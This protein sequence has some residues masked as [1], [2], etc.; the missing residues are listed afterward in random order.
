MA[1]VTTLAVRVVASGI[2]QGVGFRWFVRE[3]ARELDLA[4]WVRNRAD[5]SVELALKGPEPAIDAMV[6]DSRIRSMIGRMRTESF[7]PS[8]A[9]RAAC[10]IRRTTAERA[11]GIR[12]SSLARRAITSA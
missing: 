2:V 1:R 9:S 5:G 7:H 11:K 6:S 10:S 12:P 3:R 4:G 8:S